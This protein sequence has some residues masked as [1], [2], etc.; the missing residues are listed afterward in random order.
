MTHELGIG[1]FCTLLALTFLLIETRERLKQYDFLAQSSISIL[2]FSANLA[3]NL[4]YV[5]EGRTTS[6][7]YFD[8]N[9][10]FL[11]STSDH[12][13]AFAVA[14]GRFSAMPL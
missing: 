10:V 3:P 12:V 9:P 6:Q 5:S 11:V 8:Q 4:Y 1:S 14:F 2:C 7:L 13:Y